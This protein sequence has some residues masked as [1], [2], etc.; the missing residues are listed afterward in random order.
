MK[1]LKKGMKIKMKVFI[2]FF[3]VFVEEIKNV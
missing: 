1:V 2:P 3:D